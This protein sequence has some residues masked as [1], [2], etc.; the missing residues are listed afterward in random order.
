VT[1]D[2]V[3]SFKRKPSGVN[4]LVD[5]QLT[6]QTR[7]GGALFEGTFRFDEEKKKVQMTGDIS[8]IYCRKWRQTPLT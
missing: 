7:P 8:R 5:Y 1:S 2:K 6:I 3:L 4:N